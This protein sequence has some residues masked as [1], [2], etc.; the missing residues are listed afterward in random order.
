MSLF[1]WLLVS[2]VAETSYAF[3]GI[4]GGAR[5]AQGGT[6]FYSLKVVVSDDDVGDV[7]EVV[8]Y[9]EGYDARVL[10][11]A[12][13]TVGVVYEL[14][15]PAAV[16]RIDGRAVDLVDNQV[17]VVYAAGACLVVERDVDEVVAYPRL[18]DLY[19]CCPS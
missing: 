19:G 3:R 9:L 1:V 15:V 5:I 14:Q 16:F 4:V 17:D 18:V 13:I 10:A 6:L 2:L 8:G 7:G 11:G 12:G